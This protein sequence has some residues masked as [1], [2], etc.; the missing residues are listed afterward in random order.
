MK[1]KLPL[2]ILGCLI[3]LFVSAQSVPKEITFHFV[4]L[5]MTVG[6]NSTE[7]TPSTTCSTFLKSGNKIIFTKC[8]SETSDVDFIITGIQQEKNV[9]GVYSITYQGYRPELNEK[10]P[11]FA[12]YAFNFSTHLWTLLLEDILDNS[13]YGISSSLLYYFNKN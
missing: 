11:G 12:K 9:Q 3:L 13:T 7:Q 6:S 2:L 4:Q 8:N 1:K 5:R 10:V